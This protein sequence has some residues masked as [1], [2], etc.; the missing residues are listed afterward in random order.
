VIR[1]H[2]ALT[3]CFWYIGGNILLSCN[4]VESYSDLTSP[5]QHGDN[6][7]KYEKREFVRI[8]FAARRGIQ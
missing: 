3:G 7:I 5:A 4:G 1:A 2:Q 8:F 6:L